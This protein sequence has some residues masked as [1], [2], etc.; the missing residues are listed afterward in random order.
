LGRIKK[1]Y[2][3][4]RKHTKVERV[5][6]DTPVRAVHHTPPASGL[7]Y[8]AGWYAR[9]NLKHGYR[10]TQDGD[11]CREGVGE[12]AMA[13]ECVKE[14]FS[15]GVRVWPVVMCLIT[16]RK[17]AKAEVVRTACE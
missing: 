14:R 13:K 12:P 11:E 6:G 2:A 3:R 5:P 8:R 16:R 4:T 10:I 1:R 7:G 9:E 15:F 17:T